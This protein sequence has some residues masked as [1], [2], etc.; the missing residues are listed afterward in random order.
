MKKYITLK[1]INT[2]F[3]SSCIWQSYL[4]AKLPTRLI[5]VVFLLMGVDFC[6]IK[7]L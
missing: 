3:N 5:K 1:K 7:M 4:L 6:E 2:F